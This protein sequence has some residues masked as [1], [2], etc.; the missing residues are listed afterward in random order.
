MN[1]SA[2]PSSDILDI[3]SPQGVLDPVFVAGG[4]LLALLVLAA[5]GFA[6]YRLLR[7]LNAGRNQ[8]RRGLPPHELAAQA[9]GRLETQIEVLTPNEFMVRTSNVVKRYLLDRYDD[10]VLFETAKEFLD[11]DNVDKPMPS[12]KREAV[13]DFLSGCEIIKFSRFPEARAQCTPLLAVARTIIRES[14]SSSPPPIPLPPSPPQTS[15]AHG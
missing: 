2:E 3:V 13:G 4:V 7:S 12:S 14:L 11:R 10:P 6:I 9:L 1:P 15:V 5:L 8:R